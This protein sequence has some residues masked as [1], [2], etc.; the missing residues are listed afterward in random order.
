[1][2][3]VICVRTGYKFAPQYVLNLRNMVNRHLRAPHDFVCLT[4]DPDSLPKSMETVRMPADHF[5]G[6]FCKVHVFDLL[7]KREGIGLFFDLDVVIRANIDC[8]VEHDSKANFAGIKE[9]SESRLWDEMNTSVFRWRLGSLAHVYDDLVSGLES[10]EL[11]SVAEHDPCTGGL[12]RI[13]VIDGEGKMLNDQQWTSRAVC[14]KALVSHYPE[15]WCPSY[16][17]HYSRGLHADGKV[18]VFHGFPKPHQVLEDSRIAS[19]W[20]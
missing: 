17:R 16:K 2:S 13:K 19:E 8:L 1:M 4:D 14:R 9:W 11:K 5:K 10:G 20:R 18:I 3:T 6:S 15:E 12:D 7:R